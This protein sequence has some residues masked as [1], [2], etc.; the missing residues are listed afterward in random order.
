[1]LQGPKDQPHVAAVLFGG[2]GVL[3][4]AAGLTSSYSCDAD[5]LSKT[6]VRG[7]REKTLHCFRATEQLRIELRRG[8][9]NSSGKTTAGSALDANGNT[10]SKTDSSGTTTYSWDFENRLTSVTLPGSG[11]TVS[12]KYDPAGR[13]IQKVFTQGSSSTTT[14]YLYDGKGPNLVE[15]VD[16]NGN[17]TARYVYGLRIDEPLAELRSGTTSYYQMDGMGSATSLSNGSG[18]LAN[19]YTYDS[20]GNLVAS[21]GTILNS[22]RYTGRE[23]DSETNLYFYRAR[24]YA[25]SVGRFISEDP[26]QFK[27][28]INFYNYVDGNPINYRDPSGQIPVYGW[29]C[30]PNWT[31]GHFAPYDP[32]LDKNGYYKNPIDATDSVCRD[33]DICYANCRQIYPC[34][35]GMR[36]DCMQICD[37]KLIYYMP[38]TGV[39]PIIAAGIDF[40]NEHPNA[41]DNDPRC[42]GCSKKGSG[43]G[44]RIW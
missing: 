14:N 36:G 5:T 10:T 24:Y 34:Q 17:V 21:T 6:R 7:S 18:A 2:Q 8:C 19:T 39:G 15:E 33:H 43:S 27:G 38:T 20:F 28:G 32:S 13:R 4:F 22:F 30:G 11:G 37:V 23:F 42:P 1:M 9:G 41:G 35:K 16:A 31:G 3:P 29:W 25:P 44:N 12:F 26:I 40:F